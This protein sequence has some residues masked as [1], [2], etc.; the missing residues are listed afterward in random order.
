MSRGSAS[1]ATHLT[2]PVTI[3]MTAPTMRTR[4]TMLSIPAVMIL[5]IALVW[6]L[7]RT[8]RVQSPNDS[9]PP[10]PGKTGPSDSEPR[11][12]GPPRGKG[13]KPS[14]QCL[15]CQKRECWNLVDGCSALDGNATAGPSVGKPRRATCEEMLDCARR[16]GCDSNVSYFCYCGATDLG[17][18]IAG[19]GTGVCKQ[20]FEAAAESTDPGIVFQHL[21]DKAYASGVVE[22][23][24][25]CETRGCKEECIPY[26]R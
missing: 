17:S 14:P 12:L 25:T 2:K 9:T 20:A 18:C 1:A 6:M 26:Y 13:D 15:E 11:G 10:S 3:G 23:L 19:K 22:P 8:Q 7:P 24:L 5:A 21:K 16:T 4:V